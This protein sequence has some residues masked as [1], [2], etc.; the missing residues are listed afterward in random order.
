MVMVVVVVVAVVVCKMIE[1][2]SDVVPSDGDVTVMGWWWRCNAI[3]TE[4]ELFRW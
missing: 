1:V 2:E 3:G 4:R